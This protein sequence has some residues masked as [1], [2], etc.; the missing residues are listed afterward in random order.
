MGVLGSQ[1]PRNS[2]RVDDLYLEQFISHASKLAKK[3]GVTVESVIEARRVLEMERA[4]DL[5]NLAGD[6]HDEQMG[7]FGQ[8]LSRIAD[9]IEARQ[10]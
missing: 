7:G 2:H 5:R 10:A 6:Y 1:P 4:N 3:H 8:I 9:A